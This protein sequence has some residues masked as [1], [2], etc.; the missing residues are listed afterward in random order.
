MLKKD[1]QNSLTTSYSYGSFNTHQRDLNG[2]YRHRKSGFVANLSSFHNY[3]D[4]NYKVWGENVYVT[5]NTTGEFNYVKAKRFHDSYHSVGIRGN[6][7]FT[8]KK[9]ADELLLGFMFSETEKDIQTGA[10]M[11]VVYGNRKTAYNGRMASLQYK[12][13]IYW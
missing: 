3:T 7:G 10:T 2:S 4:N 11:Q 12:K 8:H 13:M 6:F 1:L 5:D 9:W